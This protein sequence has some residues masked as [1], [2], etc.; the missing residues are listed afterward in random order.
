MIRQGDR[1]Q[2]NYRK[3]ETL[4]GFLMQRTDFPFEVII[5]DDAS[6]D[7][8]AEIVREYEER[9]PDIIKPVYQTE[10]QYVKTGNSAK[11]SLMLTFK[12]AKGR[13]LAICE[14]DDYWTD[15]L[16]L[17]KQIAEMGKYPTCYISF[18]PAV[19]RWVDGSRE[20]EVL[21][22]H[23]DKTTIF[24]TDRVFHGGGY[25]CPRASI[26]IHRSVVPRIVSFFNIAKDAPVSDY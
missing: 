4:P 20:D 5:H 1:A 17:Q 8:T 23:S 11:I 10:N 12:A 3:S 14:G 6:T 15:P 9:Y 21:G 7:R 24:P 2:A 26:V 13:Y 25:S 16:K 19:W 18:H 22:L